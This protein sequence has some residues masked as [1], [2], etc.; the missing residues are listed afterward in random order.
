MCVIFQDRW[1]VV[2]IPFVRMVKFKFLR[3]AH[4]LQLVVF[5]WSP[6][7]RKSFQLSRTLQS[8]LAYFDNAVVWMVSIVALLFNS[9]KSLFQVFRHRSKRSNYNWYQRHSHVPQ[10][11]QLSGKIQVFVYLFVFFYFHSVHLWNNKI[12]LMTTSFF[13]SI[14]PR[15]LFTLCEFISSLITGDFLSSLSDN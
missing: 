5:H 2:H 14:N 12:H 8:F 13:L 6:I 9:A 3:M 11:F 1:W 10:L 15:L 4:Q 7:D